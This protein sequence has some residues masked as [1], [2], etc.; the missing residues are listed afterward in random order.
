MEDSK[1]LELVEQYQLNKEKY[2]NNVNVL[3][4]EIGHIIMAG[5][6]K[7]WEKWSFYASNI[8]WED[9]KQDLQI[10][11]MLA[12]AAYD[13]DGTYELGKW[14]YIRSLSHASAEILKEF[15]NKN[16]VMN[17]SV[18]FDKNSVMIENLYFN[19]DSL[20]IKT[21]ESMTVETKFKLI[22]K[23]LIE[24]S[25]NKKLK[26]K[27]KIFELKISGKKSKEISMMLGISVSDVKNSLF[28]IRKKIK[29]YLLK[30]EPEFFKN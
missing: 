14:L 18:S 17:K 25:K 7:K 9:S 4:K 11:F 5:F 29:E 28:S 23:C 3:W 1:K 21:S 27:L 20:E 30:I 10:G 8:S 26:Q 13:F 22:K 19:T 2:Y 12:M 16:A 6:Y 15:N 24:L